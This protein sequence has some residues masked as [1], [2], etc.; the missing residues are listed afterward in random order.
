[1]VRLRPQRPL[2][3]SL[4]YAALSGLRT[5]VCVLLKGAPGF[6]EQT[7]ANKLFRAPS[8]AVHSIG[9]D[10]WIFDAAPSFGV[11]EQTTADIGQTFGVWGA[12]P[13][14]YLV[15]PLLPP[16][17]LRDAVGFAFDTALD[18]LTWV[19]PI[20]AMVGVTGEKT[21]NERSLNLE[22]Y[23]NVEESVF[24]LYSAVRNAY[25]QQRHRAVREGL[26]RSLFGRRERLIITGPR[27]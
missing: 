22:L 4:D 11:Q 7:A 27:Q 12:G 19:A 24:D 10:R 26:A 3:D 9:G 17:T 8:A 23:E 14:P 16:F 5:Q 20:E 6:D 25:L 15:L 13:G 21:V 1:M 18:P 2:P